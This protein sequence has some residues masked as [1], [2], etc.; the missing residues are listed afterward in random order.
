MTLIR[1]IR[2]TFNAEASP[3]VPIDHLNRRIRALG[4]PCTPDTLRRELRAAP[5]AQLR[6]LDADD[7]ILEDVAAACSEGIRPAGLDA[8]V[9]DVG[10]RGLRPTPSDAVRVLGRGLGPRDRRARARWVRL[11]GELGGP[12]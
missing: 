12:G 9:M 5:Q 8:L 3:A 4:S 6:T 7:P 10:E 2:D 11:L 1:T